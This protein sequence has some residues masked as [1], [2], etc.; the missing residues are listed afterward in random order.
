MIYPNCQ[1]YEE[2]GTANVNKEESTSKDQKQ[3]AM[4]A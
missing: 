3:C 1:F 2:K 4:K